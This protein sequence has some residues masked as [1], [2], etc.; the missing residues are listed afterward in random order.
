MVPSLAPV[1]LGYLL[2]ALQARLGV[3][4]ENSF[5]GEAECR[6]YLV[7]ALR[8]WNAASRYWR[9][10]GA[11]QTEANTAFYDLGE[12]LPDK[13]GRTVTD[14]DLVRAI[15]Y[16][17]LEPASPTAWSGTEQFSLN[18]LTA[19]LERRRNQFLME[20]GAVVTHAVEE[21]SPPAI[22]RVVLSD[23]ILDVRRAAWR[24]VEG[25]YT[26]LW[27]ED[28]FGLNAFRQG[29]TLTPDTPQC[30]SVA[31]TPPFRV[32]LAPPPADQGSLDLLLVSAGAALDPAAGVVLG[33]PD[34][35]TWVVK[36][37][38]LADLLGKDG[39]AR[40]AHRAGYCEQR[41]R[42]GVELAR[43]ASSMM[44][45]EI[46]GVPREVASVW[47]LDAFR[48]NWQNSTAQSDTVA[49]AGLNLLAV[50]DVPAGVHSVTVDVVRNAPA[51]AADSDTITVTRDVTD[52]LIDYA[53]HLAAFKMGGFDFEATIGH[54]ERL[55]R[56]AGVHNEALAAR[57]WNLEPLLDRAQREQAQRPMREQVE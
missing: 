10:R 7:E 56:L 25:V 50:A 8:T 33:V 55:M 16:H 11:F 29:W 52:A 37:G 5:W 22:G 21:I 28:E 26:H 31:V 36:W 1:T 46:D 41:W 42:D 13:L 2:S 23:S 40:D 27:R 3:S 14:R 38:A 32:Q 51:P 44:Q 49:M 45:A 48:P 34:D 30:Y 57:A 24:T 6:L 43:L 35:F 9:D 53:E 19:A 18:D 15:E 20:T 39:P 17:L 47:E 4:G 12:K 54:Y